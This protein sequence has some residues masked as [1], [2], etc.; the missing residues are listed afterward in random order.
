MFCPFCQEQAA[1]TDPLA[2]KIF[3]DSKLLPLFSCINQAGM[4]KSVR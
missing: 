1:K 3:P 4:L 2:G